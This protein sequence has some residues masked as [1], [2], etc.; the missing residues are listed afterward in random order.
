MKKRL[1]FLVLPFLFGFQVFCQNVINIDSLSNQPP[2]VLSSAGDQ[3]VFVNLH[4]E[5]KKANTAKIYWNTINNAKSIEIKY[6]L[7][8]KKNDPWQYVKD[9]DPTATSYELTD[10]KGGKEYEWRIG[11]VMGEKPNG[12]PDVTWSDG[13]KVTTESSYGF[14]D[15]LLLI[16]SLGLFIYGMKIMSDGIQ[17][18]AGE[19]LRKILSGMTSN[20]LFG[21]ATGILITSI[22]QSSSAT[23]V[24]TVGFVNAGLL[25]LREAMGVIMGANIG[26]TVTAWIVAILGFKVKITSIAIICIGIC[27][28]LLFVKN[29]R[30]KN[31]A[32]FVIGF[33]ILF[34]GLEFLKDAVPTID[35]SNAAF[36]NI[37]S[38]ASHGFLSVLLFVGIGTLLTIVIQSSSATMAITLTFLSQGWI[39]FNTA[40]AM[41]L[42]E[43]IG[44]TITANLAALVGNV[45][46][47]RAAVFHTIFNLIG[48]FWML[49][50]FYQFTKTLDWAIG[51]SDSNWVSVFYNGNNA[52]LIEAS[53]KNATIALALYHTTFNILNTLLLVWFVSPMERFVTN[54]VKSKGDDDEEFKLQYLRA[55]LVDTPEL[56]IRNTQRI[57]ESFAKLIDKMGN[58][59]QALFFE[60]TPN[61]SNIIER[62]YQREELT[63]QI[64][65]E[66][67]SF[68]ARMSESEISKET[69]NDLMHIVSVAN[70]LE[71]VGDIFYSIT[72]QY[73]RFKDQKI[74]LPTEVKREMEEMLEL[75]LKAIKLLRNNLKDEVSK[76][77][78]APAIQLEEE[79]DALKKHAIKTHYK[80]LEKG[81]YSPKSGVMFIEFINSCEEVGDH[82]LKGQRSLQNFK[83]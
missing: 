42:G 64:E 15:V 60:K 50:I 17:K 27:F 7:K 8:L 56:S 28:P 1:L 41:V 46:A 39:D 20:R 80:Q 81:I 11:A 21:I 79:I 57:L 53:H 73:E 71:T 13:K 31:L 43:N 76:V 74:K 78:L 48:V 72:K 5:S 10:L 77:D 65:L 14:W 3:S 25:S 12:D 82:L 40:A 34:I 9:I 68:V 6:K 54:I 24:M 4:A 61:E 83:K 35:G 29:N 47:K 58:N 62:L 36:N 52:D 70:E 37:Q 55:G 45:H 2:P 67:L 22:I 33:G 26:T 49:I 38:L 16:G 30:L 18:A 23:T 75:V 44:T 66:I 19:G 32:E 63:D 59:L 51:K 69:S